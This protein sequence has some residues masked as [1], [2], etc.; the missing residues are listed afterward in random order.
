MGKVY[1]LVVSVGSYQKDGETKKRYKNV[2]VVMEGDNGMYVLL[3]RTFNPAGC[4]NDKGSET[5]LISMMEP[6][7]R[8]PKSGNNLDDDVPF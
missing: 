8:Q 1:D 4:P 5:V 2:G 6:R 7:E 3:E